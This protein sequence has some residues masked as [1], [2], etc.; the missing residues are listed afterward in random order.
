[1]IKERKGLDRGWLWVGV[2]VILVIVFF[3]ARSLTR[4]R[5]P[6]R[7]AT[8]ERAP[9]TSTLSTNGHVE[10]VMRYE[11]PSPIATTVKAVYV[12]PGDRVAKGK[13]LMVL[14][15]A[16]ARARLATAESGV[17]TA[18]AALEA[19]T[20][21]GTLEQRQASAA[22]LARD[23]IDRDQAQRNLDA[24][25]KLSA[26]GAAAPNEVAAARQQLDTVE[27][28]IHAAELSAQGRYS[29][30]EM[31]RAQAALA[32]AKANADAAREVLE[33]TSYR[34][35]IAGTVYTVDARPTEY[36]E[37]GKVLLQM[38][39][40]EHERV[41]AYFDEPD[42]GRLSVGQEIQ[43]KW[44]AKPGEVW[45]GHIVRTPITVITYTT[46]T[47]GEVMIDIDGGDGD[48][49]PDTNVT[50]TVTTASEADV[51]TIPRE[52]LYSENGKPY[53][54]KVVNDGL[55][56]TPVTTG[57]I[58][59]TQVAILAGLSAGDVVATGTTTGQPLQV[60]V[61]IKRVQ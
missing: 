29:A 8:V 20:Q 37:A 13:L 23:R 11:Y 4:E 34:A 52:S 28:N 7:I 45:H 50:V 60:G 1:M 3:S 6:V 42:I 41:R 47:V 2:A 22:E 26:S 15:D 35:P 9:L 19:A 51:L 46:R 56:R 58:N 25:T 48:L 53:V 17:K 54:F 38:A 24:L 32:D 27:A 14:D 30:A 31:A 43:I 36:A 10:P 12:Q 16:E 44:D 57:A 49:L 5:L 59:L 40:L 39:D 21:N 55:V 33:K 61:P 18:E